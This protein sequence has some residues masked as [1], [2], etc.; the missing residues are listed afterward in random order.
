MSWPPCCLFYPLSMLLTV[1][2][3]PSY[4][5]S[6]SMFIFVPWVLIPLSHLHL[7]FP[8]YAVEERW[9]GRTEPIM[10]IKNLMENNCCILETILLKQKQAKRNCMCYD[11]CQNKATACEYR[12][13]VQSCSV[14]FTPMLS[15]KL[16]F[17]NSTSKLCSQIVLN[18]NQI[19]HNLALSLNKGFWCPFCRQSMRRLGKK[20]TLLDSVRWEGSW[21][22]LWIA[23]SRRWK[24]SWCKMNTCRFVGL[25]ESRDYWTD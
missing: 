21:I 1:E 15:H 10:T 25:I 14:W 24:T 8:Q 13:W 2:H 19:I 9:D 20:M 17:I 16:W 23:Y 18:K 12:Y 4:M 22:Y 11:R 7:T 5:S 6:Y 3:K